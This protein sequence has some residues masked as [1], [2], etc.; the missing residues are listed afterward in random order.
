MKKLTRDQKV[1]AIYDAKPDLVN[2]DV[3][4]ILYWL[5]RC[6]YQTNEE[7]RTAFYRMGNPEFITRSARK[8]RADNPDKYKVDDKIVAAREEKFREEKH[9]AVHTTA[10]YR[11]DDDGYEY[12]V[13]G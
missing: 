3:G 12:A 1:A 7:L 6:G 4:L 5:E 8:V 11:V 2:D 13:I 9:N 10:A